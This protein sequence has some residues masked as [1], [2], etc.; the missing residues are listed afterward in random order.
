MRIASYILIA[1]GILLLAIAGIDEFRGAT[2]SP[3]S[4]R[5]G[6][7]SHGTITKQNNPEQ[8][9]NAMTYHWVH[10]SILLIGG[11]IAYLI[12]RGQDKSDPMS[13]DSDARI[14]E[15]LRQDESDANSTADDADERG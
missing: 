7:S 4:A 13:P 14:D 15:D 10:A 9:G 2:S 11:V 8:F 1:L 3:S 5:Y 6:G 12:D